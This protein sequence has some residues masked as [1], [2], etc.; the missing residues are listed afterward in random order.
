MPKILI[1]DDNVNICDL[2]RM[3]LEK[4]LYTVSIVHD[5]LEALKVFNEEK[6]DLVLLDIMLPGLDG[7]Q[8]CR[9]IRKTSKTPIIIVSAKD[10][11][12]DKV[13]GFELGGDDYI[14]KPFEPKEV[15]AR[16][17]A[18]IRRTTD[19][20][21][22]ADKEV[23]FDKLSINI[24]KYE[25][26]VNGELIDTPPKELELIYFLASHPGQKFSREQLLSEVWGFEYG[27]ESSRTVDVHIKRL[28]D[29]LKN[30]SPE[31][32][33]AT[34]WSRGYKFDV[35]EKKQ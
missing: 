8:V 5:G 2:L 19:S 34:V 7:W 33:I 27:G 26:R 18:V 9:E 24:S 17:K 15:V 10:E 30:V 14:T 35:H 3:Y 12:F 32:E 6:P 23:N 31:W 29:K 16:I 28:R 21:S 20:I 11:T 4:E 25:M 13:L 22:N 1:V